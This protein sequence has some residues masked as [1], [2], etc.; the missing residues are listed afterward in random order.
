VTGMIFGKV[1]ARIFG[2]KVEVFGGLVLLVIGI[3]I[4]IDHLT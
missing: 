3:K 1:L 2:K 4:I